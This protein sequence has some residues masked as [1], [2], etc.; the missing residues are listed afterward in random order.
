MT[1]LLSNFAE[2]TLQVYLDSFDVSMTIDSDDID[3]FPSPSNPDFFV[4]TLFDGLNEPELVKVSAVAGEVW[5]IERGW[6]NTSARAWAVGTGVRL[7][8]S[9]GL[10]T[11]IN[12]SISDHE[13]R[14]DDLE[15]APADVTDPD[16]LF[17]HGFLA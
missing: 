1:Q 5:T 7:A 9:A 15:N 10:F 4:V 13:A 8:Y 2:T 16:F 3:R 12:A 14:L 17:C 11:D 6:E